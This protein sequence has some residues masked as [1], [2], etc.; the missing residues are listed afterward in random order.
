MCE[1]CAP[2]EKNLAI[3]FTLTR[4]AFIILS[5]VAIALVP[6]NRKNED[7]IFGIFLC[8][9]LYDFINFISLWSTFCCVKEKEK[10]C[11]SATDEGCCCCDCPCFT[12]ELCFCCPAEE[13]INNDMGGI[14]AILFLV[15]FYLR[16]YVWI[17]IKCCGKRSRY[18]IQIFCAFLDSSL[19]ISILINNYEN[20]D[21]FSIILVALF[22][23][24]GISSILIIIYINIKY[25]KVDEKEEA[26][27]NYAYN[28]II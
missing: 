17:L 25:R 5:I 3:F 11:C 13:D 1:C 12:D 20:L 2:I 18:C 16:C 7:Q 21:V 19:G 10:E 15:F 8:S 27:N 24:S 9:I 4:F 14:I 23:L 6:R 26:I 22:L 28:D